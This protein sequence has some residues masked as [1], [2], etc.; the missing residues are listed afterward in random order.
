MFSFRQDEKYGAILIID[1]DDVAD[2]FDDFLSEQ[3]YV[4]YD[5]RESGGIMEFLFGEA[6]CMEKV[7]ELVSKYESISKKEM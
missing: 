1:C 4:F 6:A 3:C 5:V 7:Q 2:L